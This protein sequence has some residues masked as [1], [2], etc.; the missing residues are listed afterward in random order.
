MRE[1]L[2]RLQKNHRKGYTLAELMIVIAI[3]GIL[4]SFGFVEV[5]RYQKKMKRVEMD[6]TAKEIFVAAQN[7]LT[8]AKASGSWQAS[9]LLEGEANLNTSYDWQKPIG[10]SITNYPTDTT[11]Q[12][13][14]K[15]THAYYYVIYNKTDSYA[16]SLTSSF[17]A[18]SQLLPFGSV[19]DTT[20]TDGSYVIEFDAKTESVYGVFYTDQTVITVDDLENLNNDRD[21]ATARETYQLSSSSKKIP[22]GYYGGAVAFKNQVNELDPITTQIFNDG[23]DESDKKASSYG[24]TV[25]E[26][27]LEAVITD[28]NLKSGKTSQLQITLQALV[29]GK[30]DEGKKASFTLAVINTN[31]QVTFTVASADIGLDKDKI[32]AVISVDPVAKGVE[33]HITL[34]AIT[35]DYRH[36]ENLF[37]TLP[38]G[39]DFTM[40]AKATYPNA[41][42]IS[43]GATANSL[44][45]QLEN[46]NEDSANHTVTSTKSTTGNYIAD[47]RTPRHLQNLSQDVSG[48]VATDGKFTILAASLMNNINWRNF[49]PGTYNADNNVTYY[50]Q[51]YV[52]TVDGY[53]FASI[54]NT[55]L[56]YFDGNGFTLSTFDVAQKANVSGLF[57]TTQIADMVVSDV[58][59]VD[60]KVDATAQSGYLFGLINKT[61]YI[62]NVHA[63]NSSVS[64]ILCNL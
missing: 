8:A 4:M 35:G 59:L 31:N 40:T 17:S 22:V 47:I 57:S 62:N 6:N 7:H 2:R 14:D 11:N 27:T 29:G 12:Q 3:T 48:Y 16:A 13:F 28:P 1:I 46:A 44:F 5:T 56:K 37:P 25:D 10:Y 50:N 58:E 32:K 18:L 41:T 33:Y 51:N 30:T 60:F 24:L 38:A 39:E 49:F 15:T 36:F 54:Y 64:R 63:Y 61:T 26:N 34:D 45:A 42:A 21:N 52:N 55:K 43:D 53:N 23:I 19:D 9:F 20:R